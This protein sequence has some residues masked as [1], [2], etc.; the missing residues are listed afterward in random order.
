MAAQQ[1]KVKCPKCG[2]PQ[3]LRAGND[4]MYGCSCGAQ[5]DNDVNEGGDFDDRDPSRRIERRD[6][7]EH[8]RRKRLGLT[9]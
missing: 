4:V 1:P 2:R 3:P 9:K 5:F 6:E 8:K 7:A